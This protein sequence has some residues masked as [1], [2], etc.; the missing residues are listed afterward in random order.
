M[1]AVYVYFMAY[2]FIVIASVLVVSINN[3]DFATTFTGVLTTLNNV[4]PGIAAVGP[5]E[6]FAKFSVLSK[7][8]FCFDMLVG[9]IGSFPVFNVVFI[10]LVEKKILRERRL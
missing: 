4:G 7:I 8:V 9:K 2:I 1:H 6:N 3:F 5:V 10:E